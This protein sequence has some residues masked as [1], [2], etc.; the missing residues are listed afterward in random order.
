MPATMLK[1]FCLALAAASIA[2][3]QGLA[4]EDGQHATTLSRQMSFLEGAATNFES[5]S[6][7]AVGQRPSRA[8]FMSEN[9][10]R[11]ARRIADWVMDSQDNL[12]MP[13]VIVDKTDARVFVFH[14]DGRLIGAAA[15]LLGLALGDDAV[16]GI[17]N[18]KLSTIRPDERTTP[19][20]RFV[21]S[22]G[23]NAHGVE[24]LWVDYAGAISLHRVITS[25][26]KEQRAQR[27]ATPTP[28]DNRI[29][30][31][32]INVPVKFY[33]KVVHPA[34]A[35]SSGV[36]YVLPEIKSAH[37]VLGSYDVDERANRQ[38]SAGF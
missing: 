7:A 5:R 21:A 31:G 35:G 12:G 25:N 8:N 9:P 22:L 17:G 6:E 33:N 23:R 11:D 29:S 10:S 27:L 37:E 15:A 14:A 3:Q 18:R 36:V 4:G 2:P 28:L 38:A 26:P 19:A 20:G 13:F 30:Y 24:V 1:A 16:A 32:C 34:F